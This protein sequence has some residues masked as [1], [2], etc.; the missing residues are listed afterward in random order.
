MKIDLHIKELKKRGRM[1]KKISNK[2]D[3]TSRIK[4]T[5]MEKKF[6]VQLLSVFED[7]KD[8][9]YYEIDSDAKAKTAF[10]NLSKACGYSSEPEMNSETV[11]KCLKTLGS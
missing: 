7:N 4:F 1:K 10:L 6:M 5:N 9:M 2:K 3:V 8:S 11:E